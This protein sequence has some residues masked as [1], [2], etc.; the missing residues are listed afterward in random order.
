MNLS[1][2]MAVAWREWREIVRDRLF[3]VLAFLVPTLLMLVFNHGLSMDVEN[4]PIVVLDYDQGSHSRELIQSLTASRYF[5]FKGV[6][7][8]EQDLPRMFELND[9]RAGLL[10]PADF[11]RRLA[12]GRE[13]PVQILVDGVFPSRAQT[14]LGYMEGLL[15]RHSQK[16]FKPY[17]LQHTDMNQEQIQAMLAPVK[18]EIRYMYNTGLESSWSL[19]PKLIMFVL[20]IASPL[21][22][23]IG[24]VREKEGGA[25]ANIRASQVR[26]VEY[27]LGKTAPYVLIST[28]NSCVLWALA[29]SVFGA[30]F[31]GS[32]MLFFLAC[33]LFSIC[34]TGIG[35]VVSVLVNTQVAAVLVTFV[36]T[37][38]PSIQYS[39]IF[40]PV[41][42][43]G[44][45]AMIMAHLLPAMHFT[46]I[47]AGTFLK[48]AGMEILWKN[49]AVLGVYAMGLF[50]IGL[51]GFS[52]RPDS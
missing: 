6:L 10:I 45:P 41:N 36:I 4:I 9:I 52:K 25:V 51:A 35:V 16:L 44:T 7:Q 22:S 28:C 42:F 27:L 13:A 2:L 39:G 49:F 11:S 21:L 5:D 1:R 26:P 14:I 12:A 43:L 20:M 32:P 37:T 24:I 3:F 30:P 18:A 23:A 50:I 46:T 47:A 19:A 38:I 34:T 15:A 33:I 48:G 40:V 17:L 31:K 29:V 8:D